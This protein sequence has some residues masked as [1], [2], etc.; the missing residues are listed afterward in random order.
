MF[1]KVIFILSFIIIC[2]ASFN[3]QTNALELLKKV[4][5]KFDFVNDLTAD[6]KQTV[7]G[8]DTFSGKVF[9][10]KVNNLRFEFNSIVIVSDGETTWNYNKNEDKVI[11]TNFDENNTNAFSVNN[12]IYDYPSECNVS[13]YE[14]DGEIVLKLVPETS[15]LKFNSV[16]LWINGSSLIKKILVDD[17]A[18]GLIRIDLSGY[19]LNQNLS[20]DLFSFT[21]PE[22]TEVID[23]R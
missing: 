10:K 15:S 11:I 13:T 23:L 3:A 18:G 7:N 17:P 21:P 9:F 2:T 6:I 1:K 20:Q 22:G 5:D 16:D 8:K 19:K 4:Q 12:I 14:S